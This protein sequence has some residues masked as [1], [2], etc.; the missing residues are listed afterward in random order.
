MIAMAVDGL[1][2]SPRGLRQVE[3]CPVAI[4]EEDGETQIDAI[5]GF[6]ESQGCKLWGIST[7]SNGLFVKAQQTKVAVGVVNYRG[8]S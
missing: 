5:S 3:N 1:G 7:T 6:T 2:I 8:S 4:T